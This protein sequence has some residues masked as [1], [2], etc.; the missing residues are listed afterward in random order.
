M[1]TKEIT[2]R[3]QIQIY[4]N[5]RLCGCIVYALQS[6]LAGSVF[7]YLQRIMQFIK[8]QLC[9]ILARLVK[10]KKVYFYDMSKKTD[11]DVFLVKSFIIYIE[12]VSRK[13]DI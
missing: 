10:K 9:F 11:S 4:S 13:Q 5:R 8:K 3:V 6:L 2:L 1:T 7:L 12:F